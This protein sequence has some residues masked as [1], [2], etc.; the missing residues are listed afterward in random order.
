[1]PLLLI[2]WTWL[3]LSNDSSEYTNAHLYAARISG[4]SETT[5]KVLRVFDGRE[6]SVTL[7]L[8]EKGTFERLSRNEEIVAKWLACGMHN[9][10]IV[11][12]RHGDSIFH[13]GRLYEI[14]I[15]MNFSDRKLFNYIV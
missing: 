12:L 7:D 5:L 4:E 10:S 2:H 1:M 9:G 8:G 13:P 11:P 14:N 3:D 6:A 15:F